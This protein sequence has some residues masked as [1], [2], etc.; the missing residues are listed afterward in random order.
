MHI[1]IRA[2]PSKTEAMFFPPPRRSY[3]EADISRLSVLDDTGNALGF[4]VLLRMLREIG[5]LEM[6]GSRAA[7]TFRI[8]YRVPFSVFERMLAWTK[9]RLHE[10]GQLETNA[11][12]IPAIFIEF[13]GLGDSSHLGAWFVR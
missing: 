10:E 8:R 4:I 1:G 13:E 6:P 2:T 3:S 11:A 12:E 7:L 9:Q 5:D